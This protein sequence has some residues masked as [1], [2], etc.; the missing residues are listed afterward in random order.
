MTVSGTANVLVVTTGGANIAGALTTTG[1]VNVGNA[2]A[3]TWANAAGVRVYTYY[4]DAT[5]SL[6]TIF[7]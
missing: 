2:N 5:S 3:V 7:I 6:D 1:N 4:N